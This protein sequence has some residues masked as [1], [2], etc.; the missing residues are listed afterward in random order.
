MLSD[1]NLHG[2]VV[3]TFEFFLSEG[4]FDIGEDHDGEFVLGAV[5]V[6]GLRCDVLVGEACWRIGY[7]RWSKEVTLAEAVA[8]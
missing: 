5:E 3:R 6:G 4:S 8:L 1:P 2:L 7:L